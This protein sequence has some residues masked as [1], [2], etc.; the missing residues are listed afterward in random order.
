M[1]SWRTVRRSVAGGNSSESCPPESRSARRDRR[2]GD[3]ARRAT[4]H[5]TRDRVARGVAERNRGRRGVDRFTDHRI[6]SDL[7][8]RY[9]AWEKE[10]PTPLERRNRIRQEKEMREHEI[11]SRGTRWLKGYG[12]V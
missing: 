2:R 9:A 5:K 8:G 12:L 6:L 4:R 7:R 3:A 10:N 1:A 11:A